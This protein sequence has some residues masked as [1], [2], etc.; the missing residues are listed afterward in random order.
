[1]NQPARDPSQEGSRRWSASCRFP[2]WEGLG[3]GSWSQC[4]A[5]NSWGLSMN[6][7]FG[8]PALAGPNRLK[9]GLQTRGIPK[10]RFMVLL[11]GAAGILP[12]EGSEKGPAGKMPAARSRHSLICSTFMVRMQSQKRKGVFL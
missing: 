1:M 11:Q 9:A 8:V 10:D 3:V 2:S 5:S 7:P 12:A 6:R 4:T